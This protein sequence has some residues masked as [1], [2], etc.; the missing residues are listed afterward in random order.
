MQSEI[1]HEI[2]FHAITKAV[3]CWP[4]YGGRS[5]AGREQHRVGAS[6]RDPVREPAIPLRYC[7][8]NLRTASIL[9]NPLTHPARGAARANCGNGAKRILI[10]M[11]WQ[12]AASLCANLSINRKS[13]QL[14][15]SAAADWLTHVRQRI[16]STLRLAY[17]SVRW[18][19]TRG[20]VLGPE[21]W[22]A[23]RVSSA[24]NPQNSNEER[25]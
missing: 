8:F 18:N 5:H 15:N 24:V 7:S 25:T 4:C 22:T 12:P 11:I 20:I 19:E 23:R 16:T 9:V 21:N 10:I 17:F 14:L 13:P 1:L 3:P 6:V 2:C